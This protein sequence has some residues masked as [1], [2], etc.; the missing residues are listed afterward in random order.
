MTATPEQPGA[1]STPE[2]YCVQADEPSPVGPHRFA[3]YLLLPFGAAA[4]AA[5]GGLVAEDVFPKPDLCLPEPTPWLALNEVL[6]ARVTGLVIALILAAVGTW[7]LTKRRRNRGTLYYLRFQSE[8]NPDFHQDVVEK[9]REQYLDFRSISAWC[10]PTLGVDHSRRSQADL[11]RNHVVD[12]RRQLN[13][14]SAELQ[15]T[16]NDD[17]GDSGFDIAPNLIFPAALALGYDWIPPGQATLREFNPPREDKREIEEFQWVLYPCDSSGQGKIANKTLVFGR[18]VHHFDEDSSDDYRVVSKD[19]YADEECPADD[20]QSVWLELRLTNR[21]FSKPYLQFKSCL[22][23]SAQMS[24]TVYVEGPKS[25]VTGERKPCR[26]TYTGER[27]L[28]SALSVLQITEAAAY[29][30]ARTLR[31]FPN[32]IVFVAA[33][34][35][36]TVSFAVGHLLSQIPVADLTNVRRLSDFTPDPDYFP[37]LNT[38]RPY[39]PWQ[40]I[41]PMGHFGGEESPLRPMWVRDDQIDPNVLIE[42]AF[43]SN[44]EATE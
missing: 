14:M 15:R 19:K 24:R 44:E 35:P 6:P 25:E 22:K 10:D 4:A 23:N 12:V 17:T 34:T 41:V 13:E 43:G 28:H 29:W 37:W 20:V 30:I 1:S 11:S 26:L 32:A 8:T 18:W 27:L 21:D 2:L 40:R 5:F 36:K 16:T 3:Y 7:I 9:S 31:D 39:H 38:D 42:R 33:A